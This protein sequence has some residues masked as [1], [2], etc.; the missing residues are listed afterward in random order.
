MEHGKRD[1]KPAV[2]NTDTPGRVK[3]TAGWIS[4][5]TGSALGFYIGIWRMF[6]PSLF[7]LL[8][9]FREGRLT[10]SFIIFTFAKCWLALTIGGLIWTIGYMIKCMLDVG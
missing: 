1:R 6:L 8:V 10:F 7:G 2:Q 5:L 9:A 4:V 3:K